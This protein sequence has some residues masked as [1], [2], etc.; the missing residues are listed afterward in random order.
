L[1]QEQRSKAFHWS[2]HKE[3]ITVWDE[4]IVDPS[5]GLFESVE[6]MS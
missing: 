3:K 4:G 6:Q 5:T 1:R 2:L